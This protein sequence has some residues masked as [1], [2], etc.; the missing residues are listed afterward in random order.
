[1]IKRE[2]RTSSLI[3][4]YAEATLAVMCGAGLG[5]LLIA[6]PI[7]G[8]LV[9]LAVVGVALGLSRPVWLCYAV[10]ASTVLTS[11]MVRGRLIPYLIPNELVL[12][13]STG[14]AIPY[15]LTRKGVRR[16]AG[17]LM[18]GIIALAIGNSVLPFLLY[19]ARQ[20]ALST[21]EVMVLLAPLQYFLV[22]WLFRNIPRNE[23]DIRDI[24]H[25][26]LAFAAIVAGIG[27][28]QA[29]RVGFITS[30]LKTWYP[31][32][33]EEI[34]VGIGRVTSLLGAWNGLGTFLALNLLVIWAFQIV[35]TA[36]NR[37]V[38]IL[39]VAVICA[40]GLLA[41]GSYAGLIGLAIGLILLELMSS[42]SKLSLLVLLFVLIILAIPLRESISQRMAY[43]FQEGGWIPQTLNFRFKVW[44]EVF[45][46]VIQKHWLWGFHPVLPTTLSWLY[47]ESQYIS[48]LLRG[49]ILSLVAHLAWISASLFWLSRRFHSEVEIER[50][51]ATG[52]F[53]V[54][55]VLT[56]MG[57]TNS[58]F[59]F[60]GA[61]DYVFMLLGLLAANV[62][63][64]SWEPIHALQ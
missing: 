20:V 3:P 30:L 8:L 39:G 25:V 61:I 1:M 6:S 58:V 36:W 14:L 59:T 24:L 41:S 27:L 51:M 57:F 53:T 62:G 31:S 7:L 33:H 34:A 35:K 47:P 46:P 43:Q 21:N 56:I 16:P 15:I 52:T 10:V 11:G 9:A 37:P 54:I 29:A 19:L 44:K 17:L 22:F 5:A 55:V 4:F 2:I 64:T 63:R 18:V 60:S 40:T 50:Y 26:M 12:V 42:R 13:L 38:I 32:R 28:L 49:G 23:K 45:W 48:L